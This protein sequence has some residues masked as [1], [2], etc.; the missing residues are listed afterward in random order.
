MLEIS[1]AGEQ[2]L[3]FWE[4]LGFVELVRRRTDIHLFHLLCR[5]FDDA[6]SIETE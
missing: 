3:G 4:V 5:L 6:V 1:Y 2:L